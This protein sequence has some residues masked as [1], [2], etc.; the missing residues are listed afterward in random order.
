[1]TMIYLIGTLAFLVTVV[2]ITT[3]LRKR[4]WRHRRGDYQTTVHDLS[5]GRWVP[6]R[7]RKLR[8]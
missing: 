6:V 8:R 3:L 7:P 4:E 5:T 1:M 2:I